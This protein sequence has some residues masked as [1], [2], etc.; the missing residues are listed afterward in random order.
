MGSILVLGGGI[1]QIPLIK[2][3]RRQHYEPVVMDGNPK[4][5]RHEFV[6]TFIHADI[7]KP[8]ECLHA[9][10]RFFRQNPQA[11]LTVGTDFTPAVARLADHY[12]LPG[13]PIET[14]LDASD[15]IRMRNRLAA[16]GVPQPQYQGFSEFVDVRKVL[17]RMYFPLVVKP[18]DNMG[19]R[20]V[21]RVKTPEEL[22]EAAREAF[23][24]SM[25]RR[26]IVEE[27]LEGKEF[28]IDALIYQGEIF[29]HGIADRIIEFPPYFV[30]TG[31]ILPSQAPRVQQEA[32]IEVFKQGIRAFGIHTGFAKGDIFFS[33]GKAWVGEIAARLSGGFMSGYTYPYATGINLMKGALDIA[34]DRPPDLPSSHYHR[35]V[36]ERAIVT[37]RPGEVIG[38]KGVEDT[39]AIPGVRKVFLFYSVGQRIFPPR[40]NAEKGGNI[41]AEGDDFAHAS[42]AME[43]AR[44]TLHIKMREA[45]GLSK[46]EISYLL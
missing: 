23:R 32:V 39:M 35:C 8:Q 25:T 43:K 4:I 41:I 5:A 38:I 3:C 26:I 28:S 13:I 14:A 17:N 11:I 22:E 45:I 44:H 18:A 24:Y 29:I 2:E 33:K 16:E 12:D 20:G 21:R 27:M 19:A 31:H 42:T 36:I 15:K 46:S 40:N 7:S 9:A 30:E 1:M 6:K 37:E 10:R 34:L